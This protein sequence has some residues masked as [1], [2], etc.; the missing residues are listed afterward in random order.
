[1]ALEVL[2]CE[3][4]FQDFEFF[5]QFVFGQNVYK[6]CIQSQNVYKRRSSM[7]TKPK[8]IQEKKFDSN[9]KRNQEFSGENRLLLH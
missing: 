5:F 7:Y 8:C 3:F 2:N 9:R 6:S 4:G 1:M